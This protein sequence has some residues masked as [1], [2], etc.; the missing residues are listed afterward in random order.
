MATNQGPQPPS[1][2]G[3]SF[4]ENTVSLEKEARIGHKK[5]HLVWA[6]IGAFQRGI[7]LSRSGGLPVPSLIRFLFTLGILAGIAYGGMYALTVMVEPE[8]REMRVNI[9][10]KNLDR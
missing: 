4:A 10:S 7:A 1:A 5:A 6:M 8:K 2:K 3:R 9:P